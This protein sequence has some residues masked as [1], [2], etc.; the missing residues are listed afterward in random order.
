MMLLLFE[1]A[2]GFVDRPKQLREIGRFF[3][4][5]DPVEGRTEHLEVT[6]SEESDR[7]NSIVHDLS[8]FSL[9]YVGNALNPRKCL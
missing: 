8:L 2:V 6:A 3:Y 9:I 1:L 7:D 4:R 5:P